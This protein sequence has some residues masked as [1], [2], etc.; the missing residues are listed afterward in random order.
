M[1]LSKIKLW[2]NFCE[3]YKILETGVPLFDNSNGIVSSFS[4]GL[5]KRYLLKRSSS[6]E[7]LVIREVEKVLEDYHRKTNEYEGLIYM[8]YWI[9][10]QQIMPLYIGKSE[11]FGKKDNNLSANIKNIRSNNSFFCRW[12]YNYAYHLGDLSA[13][14]CLGHS[15]SKT[16]PKYICW[17]E[18]LFENWPSPYPKLKQEVYFWIHAWNNGNIGIWQEFGATSLT[19]LEYLLIGVADVIFP[20]YLLNKEGVN[21]K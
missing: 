1:S 10:N 3:K 17:A 18:K 6:M 7:N 2:N 12:G 4:Y 14:V 8:M 11:K 21:R 5:D 15:K 16:N 9:E 19:F 13:V 20:T